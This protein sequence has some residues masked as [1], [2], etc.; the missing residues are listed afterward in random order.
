MSKSLF[1]IFKTALNKG[2]FPSYW[3][4]SE[5][6]PIFKDENRALIEQYLPIKLLCSVSK[7][8]EKLIFDE[9]Y[10]IVKTKLEESQHGFRMHR[11]V[12]TQMLLFLDLLYNEFDEKD[13]EIFVLYL[14]FKKAFDT[15]PH[16]LL[17]NKVE[18]LGVGGN[19][20]KIVASY[21]S[22]RKQYVKVN[23]SESETVPVTSGVPQG[24]LLGP[25][26]FIIYI[27]DLPQ[28]TSKCSAFGYADDFK[29]VS[30]NPANIQSDLEKIEK[31][32]HNNK[33]QLNESKCHILPIKVNEKNWHSS[34]L[35]SK[36]LSNKSE[37]KDLGII[38]ATKLSWKANIK[39]RCSKAWKAFYFLKRNISNP[40]SVTGKLVTSKD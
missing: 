19:F 39:K 40:A 15:V 18:N 27:N 34:I 12:V 8:L 20:L 11:S 25:L 26:L 9:L 13:N 30:T 32:C 23:D 5:V 38:M 31:W 10:E 2:L 1:L 37:Q 21:L 35:N 7:V 33:M 6:V 22:N 14:D 4:I 3:K 36:T 16:D 17:I 29:L 28:Q 24:S